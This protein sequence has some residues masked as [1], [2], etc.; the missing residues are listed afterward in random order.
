M[1]KVLILS[2]L[3]MLL[4]TLYQIN[5]TYAKY[6]SEAAGTVTEEIGEW[7][8]RVNNTNIATGTANQAFTISQLTYNSNNYV[9]QGK[10]APGLLGY[11]DV[12]ID[13]TDSSV[14]VVYD[15]TLDFSQ[16]NLTEAMQFSSLV[17]VVDG[18]ESATGITRTGISTYT[19]IVPLADINENKTHT[20]RVYLEWD[21]DGTGT[22]DEDDSEIGTTKNI[23]V[24][25]P[26]QVK[27]SQ[28]QGETITAYQQ[29]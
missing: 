2:A 15:V 6:V 7:I 4:I 10:I 3:I 12:V 19:G 23:Q 24:S 25:I 5:S 29:P 27:V 21:D 20:V 17:R 13:A 14:A 18:V 9:K 16:M 8:V 11:F 1:K 28:Y 22:N 26:V